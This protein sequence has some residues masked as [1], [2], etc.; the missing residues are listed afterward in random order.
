M[1]HYSARGSISTAL[2]VGRQTMPEMENPGPE[3]CRIGLRKICARRID[4][5]SVNS[6][7]TSKFFLVKS[8]IL[9]F[10]SLPLM[11]ITVTKGLRG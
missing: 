5:G 11:E 10:A 2:T 6:H 4:F 9:Q 8:R 7:E 3:F 1:L